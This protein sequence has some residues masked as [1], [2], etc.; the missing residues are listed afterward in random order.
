MEQS[1][2]SF[3]SHDIYTILEDEITNLNLLPGEYISEIEIAKRFGVSRT[4]VRDVFKRLEYNHLLKAIPQK[5]TIV[6]PV[7]L[8]K[9]SEF[10]FIREKVEFGVIEEL[11]PYLNAPQLAKLQLILIQQRKLL[12]N[13]HIDTLSKSHTF[14]QLDNTFHHTLFQLASKDALWDLF[15]STLPDYQRFR[16]ISA[17]LSNLDD[18]HQLY[19][20]HIH[21]LEA[22]QTKDLTSLKTLYQKHIYNGMGNLN[23]LLVKKENYFVL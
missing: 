22:M 1:K 11:I 21:I 10:M 5:G 15:T 3:S 23:E 7:D 13:Q 19:Q 17:E 9:I 18:L 6:T 8:G 20:D 16:A 4:P 14:F 12:E 2:T